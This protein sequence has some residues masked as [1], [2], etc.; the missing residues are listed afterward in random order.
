MTRLP[1]T[2]MGK[3]ASHGQ[4]PRPLV[5]AT[6][7]CPRSQE[8][9]PRGTSPLL[10]LHRTQKEDTLLGAEL[11]ESTYAQICAG[12]LDT[13]HE[14]MSFCPLI[15]SGWPRPEIKRAGLMLQPQKVACFSVALYWPH[16]LGLWAI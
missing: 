7:P 15:F 14:F 8:V 6:F 12:I 3:E 16:P 5:A 2:G 9:S 11:T 13:F 4:R 10:L 1:T